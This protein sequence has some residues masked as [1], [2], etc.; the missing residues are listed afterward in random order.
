MS[1]LISLSC[2]VEIQSLP[3]NASLQS[4]HLPC[5]WLLCATAVH[6]PIGCAG[7][8]AVAA[9]CKF[10]CWISPMC[11]IALQ[12]VRWCNWG[13]KYIVAEGQEW[14]SWEDGA[15]EEGKT[16]LLKL[17]FLQKSLYCKSI[18]S[19]SRHYSWYFLIM[20]RGRISRMPVC[21]SGKEKDLDNCRVQRDPPLIPAG[22]R[23]LITP[24]MPSPFP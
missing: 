2:H 19:F 6:C 18:V 3:G 9:C 12:V 20:R 8:A 1:I 21:M 4:F 13:G 10:S 7:W 22:K 24:R 23:A 14:V 17:D 16:E 15:E 5:C 11:G